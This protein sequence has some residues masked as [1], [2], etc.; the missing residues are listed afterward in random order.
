MHPGSVTGTTMRT[1]G[2]AALKARLRELAQRERPVVTLRLAQADGARLAELYRIGEVLSRRSLEGR[3]EVEV[4]LE[5]WQVERL[6]R[7]G[8]EVVPPAALARRATG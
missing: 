4:R 5:G 2:L 1:D 6:A 7:E 3:E 8:V